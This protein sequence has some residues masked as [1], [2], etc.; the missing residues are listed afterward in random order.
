M[1][2]SMEQMKLNWKKK[3]R[4]KRLPKARQKSMVRPRTKL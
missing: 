2:R 1:R 3:R 4:K